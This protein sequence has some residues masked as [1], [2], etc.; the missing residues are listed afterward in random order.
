MKRLFFLLMA[1]LLIGAGTAGAQ[2][3]KKTAR[4]ARAKTTKVTRP[5]APRDFTGVYQNSFK[6][7]DGNDVMTYIAISYDVATG[8]AT[9]E[10][11]KDSGVVIP[12]Q[13]RVRE[14]KLYVTQVDPNADFD[15][16]FT[17]TMH[18]Y[19]NGQLKVDEI[20]GSFKRTS[21]EFK[22]L[23]R[24]PAEEIESSEPTMTRKEAA[25]AVRRA[26]QAAQQVPTK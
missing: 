22:P 20:S 3:K 25:E 10:Y 5:Q 14:G 21:S 1:T 18:F 19:S 4:K 9:G 12:F 26:A 7:Y 6:D 13:G 23:E 16:E 8:E 15:N 2:A 24:E 17:G 11:K